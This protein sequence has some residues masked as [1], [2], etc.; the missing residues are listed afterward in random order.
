MRALH[1][2]VSVCLLTGGGWVTAVAGSISPLI[3]SNPGSTAASPS[4]T[5]ISANS[6]TD[7]SYTFPSPQPGTGENN[8]LYGYYQGSGAG[9]T[10]I[11]P[12]LAASSFIPMT[13]VYLDQNGNPT[14]TPPGAGSNNTNAGLWAVNFTQYW[15]S[16]DAFGAHPNSLFTD[17]HFAPFCDQTLF[18]N[19]GQGPDMRS[20]NSPG[21]SEQYAVRRY[22]VPNFFGDVTITFSVQKDPRTVAADADGNLNLIMQYRNGAALMLGG[23]LSVG[24]GAGSVETETVQTFVQPGDIL[25]FIDS[26]NAND[27]SDGEFELATIKNSSATSGVQGELPEPGTYGLVG[28][29]L[30]FAAWKKIRR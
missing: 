4:D 11:T 14:N 16:L 20:P 5:S 27:Y 13:P 8:W 24:P 29:G 18:Q 3:C 6:C 2:L 28:L 25:D 26:P 1:W 15:T 21:S 22:V 30:L 10:V 19:C 23:V 12:T 7:F 17:L 9:G